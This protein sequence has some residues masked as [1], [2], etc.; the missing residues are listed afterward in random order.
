MYEHS[1]CDLTA[2]TVLG[3]RGPLTASRCGVGESVPFFDPALLIHPPTSPGSL[4]GVVPHYA[5][6]SLAR[7]VRG[8]IVIDMTA[9]IDRVIDDVARC[10]LVHTS[11]LHGAIL[12]DA[13]GIARVVHY[14]SVVR[15]NGF[16]FRDW[17]AAVAQRGIGRMREDARGAFERL[18][19]LSS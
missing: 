17:E 6:Q 1:R 18:C 8:D 11:S 7:E 16:K 5:D 9:D 19:G 4:V 12:A 2:A 14:S 10:G 3:L 13:F 15:G